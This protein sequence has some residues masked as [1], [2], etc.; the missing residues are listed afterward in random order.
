[1]RERIASI[2][3]N[4]DCADCALGPAELPVGVPPLE[5]KSLFFS[6]H[7]GSPAV[8]NVSFTIK[9]GESVALLGP[10]GSGKTTLL[11]LLTGLLT[12]DA[13]EIKL[14]GKVLTPK[15]AREVFRTV[16]FLFQDSQDQLFNNFVEEDVAYGLHR[17]GLPQAEIDQRVNLALHLTE[18]QH[19]AKRPIHH[20]SGG[21]MKRVAL[22]GLIAMRAPLLILDEP[23][24]AL[25][26][27]SSDHFMELVEHL[28]QEH[29]YAFLTVT[30]KMD[31]VPRLAQRVIVMDQGHVLADGPVRQVLTDIPLLEKARLSPPGITKYFY[32]QRRR[33]GLPQGDLPLTV[34]EA[35]KQA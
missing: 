28:H 35:L 4:P 13:G 3:Q 15:L 1:M 26:P 33:Q 20:L 2:L 10:N 22:A 16:G 17:L 7:E 21:E 29:G 6:Y 30:H 8:A 24:N 11:K 14:V 9:P 5:C 31:Y 18:A 27:A 12:P 32:E 19:L 23:Q 34:D 25:D